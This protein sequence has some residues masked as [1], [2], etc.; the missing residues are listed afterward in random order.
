MRIERYTPA[1]QPEWDTF[2][3]CSRQGTFLMRRAYMDYHS[4][5]FTDHSIVARD[6]N[7]HIIAL[8]P[9]NENADVLASHQ[10]LTYGGWLTPPRGF[11]AATMLELFEALIAYMRAAGFNK[12]L[13]KPVPHIYHRYPAEDDIYALFRAG[14]E[15]VAVSASSTIDYG[16]PLLTDHGTKNAINRIN[17]RDDITLAP[18]DDLPSFWRI[19]ENVLSA[20]HNTRPVHTLQEM[21]L[22]QSLFP[23]N[24]ILYAATDAG[25]RMLAGVIVYRTGPVAHA[26]YTAASEE[27][28]SQ[29]ILP[30]LYAYAIEQERHDHRW[31]DFGISCECG[32]TVLNVGL[33]AQK[34]GLGGRCTV[35]TTY[36]LTL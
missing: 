33:D 11:S 18:S 20:Y 24:I 1:M 12:L 13:Y 15:P 34:A 32:G 19:L 8:L 2:V 10:G 22:L 29:R 14:A 28:R 25:G 4:D 31:F 21:Q 17:R 23:D 3:D 27:A 9:A 6:K 5:R 26:Q 16:A 35:Y 36:S 7:G 30:A